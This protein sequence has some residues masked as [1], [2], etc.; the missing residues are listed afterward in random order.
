MKQSLDF[1]ALAAHAS[2]QH[3]KNILLSEAQRTWLRGNQ[4]LTKQLIDYSQGDFE[5]QL[6]GEYR[7][8]PY[9]HEMQTLG[10][11]LQPECRIREVLLKCHGHATVFARSIITDQA[12]QASKHQLIELGNVPLGHLLFKNAEVNLETRQIAKI[13]LSNRSIF[14]R[15]TLY[16]L[17]GENILVSEFFLEDVWNNLTVDY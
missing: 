3:R 15:R 7:A 11:D 14:A 5:L 17:N 2:W 10:L 6:L 8:K 1:K 13:D 12:I 4:S 9:M 16:K